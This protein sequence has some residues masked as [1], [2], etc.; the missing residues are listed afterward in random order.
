MEC[1]VCSRCKCSLPLDSF[2]FSQRVEGKRNSECKECRKGLTYRYY[3]ENKGKI[4]AQ[5]ITTN[6]NRLIRNRLF[7]LEYLKC[8]PCIDCGESDVR[9]LEF[10]HRDP[11]SKRSTIVRLV[12]GKYSIKTIA[13]EIA[14]CDVRCA[15]CHRR[16]TVER[17]GW[18]RSK[19]AGVTRRG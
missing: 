5:Q 8:H 4:V 2:H 18:Y 16:C 17:L 9:V 1:K 19:N 15:N 14:K 11:D 13:L 7:I 10:D 6:R 3:Q 12:A